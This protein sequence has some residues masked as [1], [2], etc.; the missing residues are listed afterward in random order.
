M[1]PFSL[2]SPKESVPLISTGSGL[3]VLSDT[4]SDIDFY[5]YLESA[6]FSPSFEL[7][8]VTI[9]ALFC[10]LIQPHFLGPFWTAMYEAT[11]NIDK[12]RNCVLK[13][14]TKYQTVV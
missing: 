10:R 11:Q 8:L 7:G 3:I 13:L 6:N 2:L 5:T 14:T 12:F 1:L 4:L 9:G